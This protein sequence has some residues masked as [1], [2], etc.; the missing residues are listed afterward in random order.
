LDG[1]K[2]ARF[3]E[4]QIDFALRQTAGG[5][6]VAKLGLV[7]AIRRSTGESDYLAS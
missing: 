5:R 7:L 6:A 1:L 3:T 4:Q 2:K